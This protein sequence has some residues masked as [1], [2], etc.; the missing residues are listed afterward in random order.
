MADKDIPVIE[1]DEVSMQKKFLKS[2]PKIFQKYIL[3]YKK[4][5]RPRSIFDA[6]KDFEKLKKKKKKKK[7]KTY[8]AEIMYFPS[9]IS[10]KKKK[11]K[12]KNKK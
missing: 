12:K 4:D 6:Y 3:G 10:T 9:L 5:G 7:N 8:D 11:K 1:V 2:L